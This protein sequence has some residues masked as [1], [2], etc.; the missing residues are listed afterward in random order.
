[1]FLTTKQGSKE[2]L[3][4]EPNDML[5][6]PIWPGLDKTGYPLFL[7][8]FAQEARLNISELA[9]A[10]GV[11]DKVVLAWNVLCRDALLARARERGMIAADKPPRGP[12]IAAFLSWLSTEI[13]AHWSVLLSPHERD[14]RQHVIKATSIHR[15]RLGSKTKT[16]S[17]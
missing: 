8:L 6:S 13:A 4:H 17:T 11:D 14:E 15:R 7:P 3:D 9:S 5:S 10:Y 1:M 2:A 16:T 12:N